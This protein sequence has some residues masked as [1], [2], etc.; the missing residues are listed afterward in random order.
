MSS[1]IGHLNI[2]GYMVDV[3]ISQGFWLG[4]VL[5]TSFRSRVAFY[6]LK[7]ASKYFQVINGF[8][9]TWHTTCK[10]TGMAVWQ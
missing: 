1:E 6:F 4:G 7:R 2:W 5:Y 8:I 3:F 10:G 9:G